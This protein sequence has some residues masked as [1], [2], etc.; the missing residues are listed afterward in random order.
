VFAALA[1]WPPLL[2]Y[3]LIAAACAVE[4]F[5]PPSPSDVFVV[6]GAFFSHRGGYEPAAVFATALV[7]GITGAV[8]V[9]LVARRHADAFR[10]SRFGRLLLPPDAAAFL[11]KGYGRYGAAGM[12]LTRL[13]PGF[14]S[15]V[16][17]FAG[18]AGVG[19]ARALVPIGLACITWYATLTWIGARVGA[20]WE[21]INRVLAGLNRILIVLAVVAA[22]V[23]LLA[24][25]SW[26]R[27]RRVAG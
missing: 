27:R 24:L 1:A 23:F 10:Q 15:V 21:G 16:A 20:E 18:L 5:F 11:L 4:N 22:A 2:I 25:R 14:R 3:G 26:R 13:L 6:M 17:P 8:V 19:A 7:G 12:F 9:Y